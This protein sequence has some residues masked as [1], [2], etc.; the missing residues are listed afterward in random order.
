MIKIT[1]LMKDFIEVQTGP[2][3]VYGAGNNGC[4]VGNYLNRCEIEWN[5]YIDQ[6]IYPQ[7]T[8]LNGHSIFSKDEII[9]KC[10]DDAVIRL[11]I[12]PVSYQG[13]LEELLWLDHKHNIKV[14]CLVPVYNDLTLCKEVYNINK[15]LAYFRHRLYT[16]NTPTII[17]NDCTGGMIYNA[18]DM[19]ML[20]PTVNTEMSPSDFIQ[21]CKNTEYYLSQE[22]NE[23][24]LQYVKGDFNVNDNLLLQGQ[25]AD[26]TINFGHLKLNDKPVKRWNMMRRK[27]NWERMVYVMREPFIMSSSTPL[28][29]KQEFMEL[30]GKKMFYSVK[31]SICCNGISGFYT[32]KDFMFDRSTPIEMYFNLLEWLDE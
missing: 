1:N 13:I 18:M 4:H 29:V 17:C 15:C 5:G 19:I 32:P 12:T 16:G 28:K 25:I 30:K 22:M 14:L 31:S 9:A 6:Q 10:R 7:G 20:S 26:I 21:F 23:D 24:S 3:F 11:L 2:L 8:T 27:I